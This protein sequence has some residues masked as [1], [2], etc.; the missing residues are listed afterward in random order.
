MTQNA[1]EKFSFD[2]IQDFDKHINQS[3]PNYD[4]MFNSIVRLSDY[5]KDEKKIVYDVG[6]STGNLLRYF[7]RNNGYKGKMIGLDVSRNLLPQNTREFENIDFV[8]HDLTQPYSFNNACIV[9]SMYT[10]QFLPKDARRGVLKSIWGGL[11]KGGAL[12]ICEKVYCEDGNYQDMFTSTYYDYKKQSFTEK[13]IFDKERSLRTMLKPNTSKENIALLREAGFQK[14]E[15]FYK[16]F[17]FE[18]YLC[19]K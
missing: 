1:Q 16:Y 13:E 2:T 6:C 4:V 17:Q 3:I 11:C 18:G 7:Q 19:I 9:Y 14:I 10:L 8:E 5:F 15:M 12:F